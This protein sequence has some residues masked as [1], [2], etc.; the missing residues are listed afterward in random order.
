MN[1]ARE[2]LDSVLKRMG[3][4]D[5]VDAARY[6]SG[7]INDTFKVETARGTRYILQRVNTGIFKD[8]PALERTVRRVTSFLAGKGVKSLEVVAYEGPW[9]IYRFLEGYASRDVVGDPSQAYDV[10]RA[11]AGFQNALSD[12][13][14]PRLDDIIPKFHDTPDRLRQLDEAAAADAKGRRAEVADLLSFVDSRRAEAGR[15]A[16]LVASG[17]IPERVVHNDTK[18]NNVMIDAG[19]EAVVIDLDTVMAGSAL[20][21][22]GDMVRTST[23]SAAEDEADLSKVFSRREYFAALARGYLEGAKFLNK[24]ERGNL[25]FAGWLATFEVGVRFLTDHLA[26]D[27]YFHIAYPGHNLVRARNQFKMAESLESLRGEYEGVV[28]ELLS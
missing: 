15:L 26:G 10:G 18:I 21:D 6:G 3:I 19:G 12:L 25:V 11:F 1:I 5:A 28:R 9:R 13:P 27:T 22:F 2:E 8:L 4:L 7:H 17:E 20:S 24:A 14:P 16:A 23:A